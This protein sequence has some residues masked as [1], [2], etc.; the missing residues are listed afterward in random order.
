MLICTN[1]FRF[2]FV[3]VLAVFDLSELKNITNMHQEEDKEFTHIV[4]HFRFLPISCASRDFVSCKLQFR[5]SVR[6]KIKNMIYDEVNRAIKSLS[7]KVFAHFCSR[8]QNTFNLFTAI[9][10]FL[11]PILAGIQLWILDAT[12]LWSE[13]HVGQTQ[14][15]VLESQGMPCSKV[16]I[17]KFRSYDRIELKLKQ[18]LNLINSKYRLQ[19]WKFAIVQ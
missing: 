17:F 8:Q 15:C 3:V 11:Q 5:S 18:T 2:V 6:V 7:F 19:T 12:L 10:F 9:N 1:R 16:R 14:K 13:S 4:F